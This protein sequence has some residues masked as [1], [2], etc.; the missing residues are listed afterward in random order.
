[1]RPARVK[2]AGGARRSRAANEPL[3]FARRVGGLPWEVARE[4][5]V[6]QMRTKGDLPSSG[7]AAL[8]RLNFRT[9]L[10]GLWLLSGCL[11][12]LTGCET[13]LP[14]DQQAMLNDGRA[15]YERREYARAISQLDR[16]L[17]VARQEPKIAEALY[18]RG[19]SHAQGGRRAQA[20]TDLR[21]AVQRGGN[22]DASWRAS[23]VLGTMCFE[24]ERWA[25]SAAAYAA[26]VPRMAEAE[27]KDRALY[28]W[29]LACERAGRWGD[30]REPFGQLA[31]QFPNSQY[32]AAA[33]RRLAQNPDYYAVQCGAFSVVTNANNLVDQLRRNNLPAYVRR[34]RR[35]RGEMYI[36][37][38][39]RYPSYSEA[40]RQLEQV[41]VYVP[42]ALIWP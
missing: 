27:G 31:K 23:V 15:A 37:L 17:E 36:V 14:R 3:P 41:R 7:G 28:H 13:G 33:S 12:V 40:R 21:G 10:G 4:Y 20:Y 32:A 16:F 9:G 11:L 1:M 8:R 18:L 2:S 19:M 26:G 30:A 34:E 42:K 6:A 35:E 39:G 5:A 25:D 38:V 24:E 22:A 29:G